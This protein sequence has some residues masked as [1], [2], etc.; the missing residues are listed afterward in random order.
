MLTMGM[1]EARRQ[2]RELAA[3]TRHGRERIVL[4]DHGQPTAVLISP[5]DASL[6]ELA[7]RLRIRRT[8]T[9][10]ITVWRV[11]TVA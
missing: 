5:E 1:T 11:G 7:G 8:G 10:T 2:L 6:R 3:R 4:T 9:T